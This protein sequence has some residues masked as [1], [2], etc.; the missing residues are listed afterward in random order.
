MKYRT[1]CKNFRKWH[2]LALMYDNKY[3]QSKARKGR[4]TRR[5]A[6]LALA[7]QRVFRKA[8][9]VYVEAYWQRG[10]GE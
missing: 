10:C 7:S 3:L 5:W 1:I 2:R 4:N 8:I 6:D 9:D